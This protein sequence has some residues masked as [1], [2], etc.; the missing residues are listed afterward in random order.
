[1]TKAELLLSGGFFAVAR[2]LLRLSAGLHIRSFR[3]LILPWL[4]V[5]LAFVCM[6]NA[7]TRRCG[8]VAVPLVLHDF[9]PFEQTAAQEKRKQVAGQ[10]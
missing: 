4:F 3:K 9:D 8:A 5:H 1:M 7:F 6:R 10:Y 2:S